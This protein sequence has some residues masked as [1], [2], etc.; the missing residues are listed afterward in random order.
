V[1]FRG[2]TTRHRATK[3]FR[4][5]RVLLEHPSR[6]LHALDLV[7]A[8][9]GVDRRQ[10]VAQEDAGPALD[11]RARAEYRAR[12]EQLRDEIADAEADGHTERAARMR[13]E[14]EFLTD[15]LRSALGLGGRDRR[16]GA[17]AE[18]ARSSV[19]KLLRRLL[20][21]LEP[22]Q[23]ELVRHLRATLRTGYFCS[24]ADDA[25]QAVPWRLR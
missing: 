24:Y 9:E 20:D 17:H 12:L 22:D 6:E 19:T 10:A 8:V 2:R 25:E 13:V 3:G 18:Q 14:F 7:G 5:L 16:A 11:D 1:S 21:R 23:P 15:E 4:Y